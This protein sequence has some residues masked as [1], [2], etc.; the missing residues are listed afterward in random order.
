ME[1]FDNHLE[2]IFSRAVKNNSEKQK[3]FHKASEI[4]RK[5]FGYVIEA[6]YPSKEFPSISVTGTHCALN[7]KHCGRKYLESMIHITS[8]K[9]LIDFCYEHANNGGVGCLIS[10][11][12]TLNG[13]VPL[14]NF[15]E[16]IREVKKNT[17][18]E[19][20][21]HT[22]LVDRKLAQKLAY[23]NVDSV[24][25]DISGDI[26]IIR[27]IYGLSKSPEDY[28][29][30]LLY[31]KEANIRITP[32]IGIGFYYSK[33]QHEFN[34]LQM[35]K[36]VDP[37]VL[38]FVVFRPTRGTILENLSPPPLDQTLL[39]MAIARIYMKDIPISMG[40]MRPS[41]KYRLM[42]EEKALEIAANRI[43][44]PARVTVTKFIK[45][46]FLI[47]EFKKCCTL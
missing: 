6:Y 28:L 4:T 34:A 16:A 33:I 43:A 1:D 45:K 3:I 46:G 35:I 5:K 31:L 18:L 7:C 32:H 42:L 15:I 36:Q 29:N 12:Y 10:G 27:E 26:K 25:I 30:A 40:C 13:M 41:G 44:T 17:N 19:I 24:S 37:E 39:V 14:D 20:N 23:A 11:G 38:V 8:P 2:E 22:G 9:K 47:K 21:V